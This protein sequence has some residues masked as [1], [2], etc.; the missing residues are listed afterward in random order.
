MPRKKFFNKSFPSGNKQKKSAA[1]AKPNLVSPTESKDD[2]QHAS[3]QQQ[4]QQQ[5]QQQQQSPAKSLHSTISRSPT[6]PA[7]KTGILRYHLN[8]D[9]D[10]G[11]QKKNIR[12]S[13]SSSVP[14]HIPKILLLIERGDWI[15]VEERARQYPHECSAWVSLVKKILGSGCSSTCSRSVCSSVDGE[16]RMVLGTAPS[17]SSLAS[18]ETSTSSTTA[19]A[20][21]RTSQCKALHHACKKLRSVH[22][23]I[24]RLIQQ[25]RS[26]EGEGIDS[27]TLNSGYDKIAPSDISFDEV[28]RDESDKDE[29]YT[30]PW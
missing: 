15:S 13:S 9:N 19:M 3:Q 21:N 5:Q 17:G 8:D 6:I 7:P 26:S 4:H 24:Q 16:G 25:H 1:I 12:T 28:W 23:Q 2:Q 14:K 20:C 30:D 10:N 18:L 11:K 22:G 27:G 29:S